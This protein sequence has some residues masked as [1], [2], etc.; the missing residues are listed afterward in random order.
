MEL[1]NDFIHQPPKGYS[2]EVYEFKRNIIAIWCR[3]IGEFI[4]ND[5]AP[6]KSIW[7]FY[8]IKKRCYYAPIN[9]KKCGKEVDIKDTTPYSAMQI[10]KPLAPTILNFI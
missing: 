8:N 2:Y 7:G 6:S 3:H 10:I 9:H 1:P 5:G 4:Y